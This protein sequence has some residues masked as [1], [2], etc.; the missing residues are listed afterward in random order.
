MITHQPTSRTGLRNVTYHGLLSI[1]PYIGLAVGLLHGVVSVPAVIALSL[2]HVVLATLAV[3]F[4]MPGSYGRYAPGDPAAP[5][6][7][8]HKA[9][10]CR[11]G[12]SHQPSSWLRI[13]P[14]PRPSMVMLL[15]SL[16]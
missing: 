6:H 16:A 11:Q 12:R 14:T 9:Q 5:P 1:V 13:T 10:R 15:A 8:R 7:I 4:R 3:K 2:M